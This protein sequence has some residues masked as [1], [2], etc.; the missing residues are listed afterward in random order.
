MKRTAKIKKGVRFVITREMIRDYLKRTPEER[1]AWLQEGVMLSYEALSPER[2]R[3]WQ[4][5]RR[6]E[7]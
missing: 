3:V 1:L 2:L 5:F 6:G 4:K 7:I